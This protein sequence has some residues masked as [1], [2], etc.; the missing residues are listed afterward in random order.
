[1]KTCSETQFVQAVKRSDPVGVVVIDKE[2]DG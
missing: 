2:N 1:M